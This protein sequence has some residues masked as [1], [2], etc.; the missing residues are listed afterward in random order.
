MFG[1]MMSVTRDADYGGMLLIEAV[2]MLAV[3]ILGEC[4]GS[5]LVCVDVMCR[6]DVTLCY[7][8]ECVCGV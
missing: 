2:C 7:V 3:L 6:Y 4:R 5:M 1:C 8:L